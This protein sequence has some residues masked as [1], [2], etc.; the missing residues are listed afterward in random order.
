MNPPRWWRTELWNDGTRRMPRLPDQPHAL[1]SP[2]ESVPPRLAE[3][4]SA[5]FAGPRVPPQVDSAI[6]NAARAHLAKAGRSNV[7]SRHRRLL[8]WAG[9][10]AAAAAAVAVF[11]GVIRHHP[12]GPSSTVAT[13]PGSSSRPSQTRPA[14]A[15]DLDGNGR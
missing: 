12:P 7:F 13:G 1:P 4:L 6:L 14:L 11:V 3:D 2:E 8:R 9:A 10:G 5:L 15:G